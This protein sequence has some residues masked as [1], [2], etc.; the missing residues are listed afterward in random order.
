MMKSSAGVAQVLKERMKAALVELKSV[1]SH[2]D[3]ETSALS[4]ARQPLESAVERQ[5]RP[6]A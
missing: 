2:V 5:A 6:G 3:T 4:G 1:V